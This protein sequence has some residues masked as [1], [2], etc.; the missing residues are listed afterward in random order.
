LQGY[1]HEAKANAKR[2]RAVRPEFRKMRVIHEMLMVADAVDAARGREGYMDP[3]SLTSGDRFFGRGL[4]KEFAEPVRGGYVFE[5]IGKES[6]STFHETP[7]DCEPRQERAPR[8]TSYVYVARPES[9]ATGPYTFALY[10]ETARIHYTKDGRIPTTI[11]PSVSDGV[12]ALD[13]DPEPA[14]SGSNS[15]ILSR[16]WAGLTRFRS[17][18]S[19]SGSDVARGEDRAIEDLR[20]FAAAQDVFFVKLG[21]RGYGSVEA[22]TNPGSLEGVPDIPPFLDRDFA[23]E[24][25]DGYRFTFAGEQ[26]TEGGYPQFYRDYRYVAVPVGD[27]PAGRRSFAVYDDRVV[28]Y[29][30]DGTAPL[31]IDPV[32]GRP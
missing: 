6:P 17:R 12:S 23:R 24:V 19:S 11:D 29:R 4:T 14:S 3:A 20:A 13:E 21:T 10:S 26:D 27:S 28:R 8:Y 16:L 22:L 15:G 18:T 9:E 1:E 2:E 7:D 30:T 32:V 25:R 31:K 5:F